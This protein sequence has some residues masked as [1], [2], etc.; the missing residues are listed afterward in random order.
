MDSAEEKVKPEPGGDTP[1]LSV[2]KRKREEAAASAKGNL[3]RSEP[4]TPPASHGCS[5]S[6]SGSRSSDEQGRHLPVPDTHDGG[7][8]DWETTRKVLERIVTPSRRREFATANP[9]DIVA[10][11]HSAI[12][13]V[14][15]WIN[16]HK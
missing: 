16:R 13:K 4:S 6:L 1:S 11:T 2:K 9:S 10:A 3:G 7:S 14:Y 15:I 12:L 8:A 5:A